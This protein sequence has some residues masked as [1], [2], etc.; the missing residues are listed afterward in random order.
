M[1]EPP[2][3]PP[4]SPPVPAPRSWSELLRRALAE[5]DWPVAEGALRRLLEGNPA[6]P[7]Q[8]DLLAYVLLM[9]GRF[10]ACEATLEKVLAAGGRSFWTPHKL[11]DAR[12]GRQR[13]E[14]AAVAYEQALAWGSD[15]PLT[16]RNLLEVLVALNPATA[17][18]RL[19][20]LVA[21][22]QPGW[23]E[24]AC[25]AAASGL[26]PQLADWL[27]EQGVADAT[28][29]AL[30]C[31]QRLARLDLAGTQA[32]L[33]DLDT[34]WAAPLRDRLTQWQAF[35]RALPPALP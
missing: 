21:A 10:G 7:H 19:Q 28:V 8:L 13:F 23:Q 25:A 16:V 32:L 18:E 9:Q 11:G 31:Q 20:Q 34:P 24:G 27:C 30:V 15:S 6:D 2:A 14:A 17:L 12:R 4:V 3:S 35:S 26:A 29:K 22:D 1:P 5:A 33:Q